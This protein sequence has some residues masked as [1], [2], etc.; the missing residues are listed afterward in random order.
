MK[1]SVGPR[2]DSRRKVS[3]AGVSLPLVS[4]FQFVTLDAAL[5]TASGSVVLK[6]VHE[7]TRLLGHWY[8]SSTLPALFDQA[9]TAAWRAAVPDVLSV[10]AWLPGVREDLDRYL[11]TET[12]ASY[13]AHVFGGMMTFAY[14]E[15]VSAQADAFLIAQNRLR[16]GPPFTAA[17]A[18][19]VQEALHG[20]GLAP[21]VVVDEDGVG[22]DFFATKLPGGGHQRYASLHLS[23]DGDL[24]ALIENRAAADQDQVWPVMPDDFSIR[25]AIQ[26]ISAFLNA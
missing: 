6:Y 4:P 13:V 3:R 25:D 21:R 17:I 1:G 9:A 20:E 15:D 18:S 5:P 14:V 24:T 8:V 26:R 12:E 11:S 16:I 10:A 7:Q 23:H 2:H 19:T 22:F